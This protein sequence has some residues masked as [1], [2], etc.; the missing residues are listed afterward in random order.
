[1]TGKGFQLAERVCDLFK[2]AHEVAFAW[3]V[4]VLVSC[5]D[6]IDLRTA[7]ELVGVLMYSGGAALLFWTLQKAILLEIK[8]GEKAEEAHA[9]YLALSDVVKDIRLTDERRV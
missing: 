1:M 6:A 9:W 2:V 3:F 8:R 7:F 4:I 5:V